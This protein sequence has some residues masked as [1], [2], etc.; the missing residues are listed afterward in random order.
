MLLRI[1]TDRGVFARRDHAHAGAGFDHGSR[2]ANGSSGGR[3]GADESVFGRGLQGFPFLSGLGSDKPATRIGWGNNPML[4]VQRSFALGIERMH[5]N[6]TDRA[7]V[8]H[9]DGGHGMVDRAWSVNPWRGAP[10]G[11]ARVI[12][13]NHRR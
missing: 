11:T 1:I 7:V 5:G 2:N 12:S 8:V 10:E 4:Q 13:V 9:E 6:D 3:E